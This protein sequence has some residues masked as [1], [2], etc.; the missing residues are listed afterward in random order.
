[1]WSVA[2]LLQDAAD[3]E[4]HAYPAGRSD[5]RSITRVLST[6]L[7]LVLIRRSHDL[8]RRSDEPRA[9]GSDASRELK[10][11]SDARL[12]LF[13][14]APA[15]EMPAEQGAA[16][17]RQIEEAWSILEQTCPVLHGVSSG[18]A[19]SVNPPLWS[20]PS[21]P[22]LR[23]LEHMAELH[24]EDGDLFGSHQLG[25]A[26]D[27]VIERMLADIGKV[28]GEFFTTR[29]IVELVVDL[30]EPSGGMRVC[31]P[32][33]GIGGFLVAAA[34][35]ARRR[36][37]ARPELELFGQE[38]NG[39][40]AAIAQLR[41]A[42]DGHDRARIEVGD[43]L[44]DPRL[45]D[46]GGL[47]QFDLVVGNPPFG[48]SWKP[49]GL[50]HDRFG[51]FARGGLARNRA[52]LAFIL[53]MVATL[54]PGGRAVAVAAPGVLFRG[55]SEKQARES[56]VRDD[57]ITAIIALPP[58]LHPT[59]AVPAAI[60]VIDRAK[61]E[62]R[63]GHI[64]FIDA[65]REYVTRGRRFDLN[66]EQVEKISGTVRRFE[67]IPG[68]ARVVS[69]DELDDYNLSVGRYIEPTE[70]E[71]LDLAQLS[72]RVR[73]RERARDEAVAEMDRLLAEFSRG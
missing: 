31:D 43:T 68:Y 14:A 50:K 32:T 21:P 20:N 29:A 13:E 60:L 57:L 1:M 52:D 11:R 65:S 28:A 6:L 41:L 5:A 70:A 38:I 27:A 37:A 62:E 9:L 64:L 42:L 34:R 66:S 61:S 7:A 15:G 72:R 36:D 25:P 69:S 44:I 39:A 17:C 59:T 49:E 73:E 4:I 56:L 53:H 48:L 22:L 63:R 3:E 23:A 16:I 10:P 51:R 54:R 24:F 12:S 26:V 35:R 71:P 46:S 30:A 8:L 19:W 58:N 18:L 47:M 40:Y 55:G 2:A 67:S 45:L 33:C